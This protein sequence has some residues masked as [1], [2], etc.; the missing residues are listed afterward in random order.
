[1]RDILVAVSSE[2]IG[3]LGLGFGFLGMQALLVGNI[4]ELSAGVIA[5]F[6]LVS[7]S[8]SNMHSVTV[9]Q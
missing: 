3:L 5:C 7:S 4:N 2:S 9:L 8:P 1:M 6:G